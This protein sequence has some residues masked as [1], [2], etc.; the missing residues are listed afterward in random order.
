MKKRTVR[1]TTMVRAKEESK[2]ELEAKGGVGDPMDL[3]VSSIS[4]SK[5]RRFMVI[6]RDGSMEGY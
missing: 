4:G 2:G 6:G 5:L 3:E 1:R